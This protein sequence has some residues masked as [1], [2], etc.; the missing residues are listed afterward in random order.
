MSDPLDHIQYAS[1]DQPIEV[2]DRVWWVGH[3]LP[4]DP[5]QCHVYLIEN[6]DQSLLVDPGSKLT[7]EHTLS[8]IE[9]IT[10]FANI[11][12]FLCQHQDP[13]ITA[14]MP[15]IDRMVT[16]DDAYLLSHWRANVLLKHYGL[17]MPM[18]CIERDHGWHLDLGDRRLTFVFTPYL[19]FP[20]AF[21][22]YDSESRT[23]FSSDLFGGFTENWTL[24]AKDADY[25]E[26]MRPFHEH[27]MPSR[28]VLL[29]GLLKLEK[30]EIGMIAPQHGSIIPGHLVPEIFSRL[31]KL[32]CGLYLNAAD[33]TDVQRL[34]SLNDMLRDIK[35]AMIAHREFSEIVEALLEITQRMLPAHSME[36]YTMR[37]NGQGLRISP[38]S[39]Y[40]GEVVLLPIEYMLYFAQNR[41]SWREQYPHNYDV[42]FPDDLDGG[43]LLIPL[44]TLGRDIVYALFILH[45][46]NAVE[47]TDEAREVIDQLAFVLQVAVE[48]KHT[49]EELRKALAIAEQANEENSLLNKELEHTLFEQKHLNE[50]LNRANAFIRK[51]FGRYMS[52]EVVASILDRPEGLRLGGEQKDVTVMMSDLRGF[53]SI[54]ERLPPEEVITM[55]NIYLERMTEIILK[56]SGTIIEFLGDGILALFG[57]PVTHDDDPQRAVACALEMQQAM[58]EVNA[59]FKE[60]GF[61]EAAMGVGINSGSVVA[62]NIG[63]DLRAKYGVVG[64]AINLAARVESQT[65][66]GQVLITA[67]TLKGCNDLARIDDAWRVSLKGVPE[68]VPIYLVGGIRG[69][70]GIQLPEPEAPELRVV[71]NGPELMMVV[72]EGK[73]SDKAR[74]PG[75]ICAMDGKLLEIETQLKARHLTNL[76][77]EL[78]D[79]DGFSISDQL[80]GKVMALDGEAGKLQLHLTSLPPEAERALKLLTT[81]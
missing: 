80:Y 58:P 34:T 23:L 54:S 63:S 79:T 74:H 67:S 51:T 11:R 10:E 19:H 17:E 59:K 26:A 16:R 37:D 68:P 44:F 21:C 31:K 57:A 77:L 62:G 14:I 35:N 36:F 40:D 56:Y 66:G 28:E 33:T 1:T 46:E 29:N 76:Q 42:Q 49:Q 15:T 7:F 70:H 72:L 25:F 3:Y 78:F 38:E 50:G 39:G 71:E 32:D 8:K 4:G 60:C 41:S 2:A 6:G 18:K 69:V 5:F 75:R 53:T 45:L 61:P 52:D 12:Y 43:R 81:C 65:V 27:Y 22:T 30:L 48:R 13:D 55:L 73:R 9:Q 24:V 20:G 64:A 47:I